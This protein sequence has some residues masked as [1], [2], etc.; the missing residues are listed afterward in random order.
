MNPAGW[1]DGFSVSS[2]IDITVMTVVIYATLV[3][4]HRTRRTALILT[5]MMIV[6]ISYLLALW[7][8]LVLTI[9]VLQGFFAVFLLALVIIFQ[10]ELRYFFERIAQWS[11]RPR[12]PGLRRKSRRGSDEAVEILAR[13]VGDLAAE[14]AGALIVVMLDH[15]SA[16]GSYRPPASASPPTTTM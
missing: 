8:G 15:E 13:T 6:G 10:E 9:A 11:L 4:L 5:G 7:F 14:R 3:W 1:L 16:A 12:L 2:V